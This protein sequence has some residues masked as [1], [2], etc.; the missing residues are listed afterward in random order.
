MYPLLYNETGSKSNA[1]PAIDYASPYSRDV[2]R[3]KILVRVQSMT[4]S[5]RLRRE[6]SV[7]MYAERQNQ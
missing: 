1:P 7:E 3:P 2:S 4:T 6:K 5:V